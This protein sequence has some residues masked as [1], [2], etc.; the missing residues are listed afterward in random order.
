M[1]AVL[2]TFTGCKDV[3]SL[4]PER[5]GEWDNNYIGNVIDLEYAYGI[6]YTDI[7]TGEIYAYITSKYEA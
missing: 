3:E 6:S 5:Y 2:F 1:S 7:T 4:L